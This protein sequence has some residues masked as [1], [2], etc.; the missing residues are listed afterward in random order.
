[1]P[2]CHDRPSY[3]Y[4]VIPLVHSLPLWWRFMQ[5]LKQYRDT[6]TR[7][8]YL[9]NSFKYAFA[10][11]VIMFGVFKPHLKAPTDHVT[12]YQRIWIM[13][14]MCSTLY[15]FWWD[16]VMDWGLGWRA[17]GFLRETLM[18]SRKWVYWA[19]R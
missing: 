8:P 7:W 13:T 12:V 5:T 1:M 16:V 18:F 17:H 9:G 15:S 3:T 19:V 10:Q 2:S 4:V 11:S 14:F 6:K